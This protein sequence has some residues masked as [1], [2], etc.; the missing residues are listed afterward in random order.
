MSADRSVLSM[1]IVTMLLT[2]SGC[3]G[4][5]TMGD[6]SAFAGA[7]VLSI[8][9]VQTPLGQAGYGTMPSTSV[10]TMLTGARSD[11]SRNLASPSATT[12]RSRPSAFAR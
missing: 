5:G 11:N 9:N 2:T 10:C 6:T 1:G 4:L 8:G 12:T 7:Q 3:A